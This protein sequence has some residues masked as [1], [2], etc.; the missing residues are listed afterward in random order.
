MRKFSNFLLLTAFLLIAVSF[1]GCS[2]TLTHKAQE[3]T[4]SPW[5]SPEDQALNQQE[6]LTEDP[7]LR[8]MPDPTQTPV[9]QAPEDTYR[10][11]KPTRHPTRS[12][13]SRSGG[14]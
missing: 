5:L 14:G 4:Q 8:Q 6:L 10:N 12:S 2:S 9:Q 1:V 11:P 13:D 7:V 3:T